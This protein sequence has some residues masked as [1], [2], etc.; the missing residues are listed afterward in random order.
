MTARSALVQLGVRAILVG[1]EPRQ[2]SLS[3]RFV[4]GSGSFC[5][6]RAVLGDEDFSLR[7]HA[8]LLACGRGLL[9]GRDPTA[10]TP[11]KTT[12]KIGPDLHQ[13]SSMK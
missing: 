11:P 1:L 5:T 3:R 9:E 2:A 13:A 12:G 6:D 7:R 10:K 8:A 4:G